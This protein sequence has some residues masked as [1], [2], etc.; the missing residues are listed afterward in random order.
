MQE[1]LEKTISFLSFSDTNEFFEDTFVT[2]EKW[3]TMDPQ[4]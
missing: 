3:S 1:K 4:R 2:F